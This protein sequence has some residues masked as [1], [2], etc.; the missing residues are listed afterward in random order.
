MLIKTKMDEKPN[1]TIIVENKKITLAYEE[2]VSKEDIWGICLEIF[3]RFYGERCRI[4]I[5]SVMPHYILEVLKLLHI[6]AKLNE[7]TMDVEFW[8][9]KDKAILC[10]DDAIT[11]DEYRIPVINHGMRWCAMNISKMFKDEYPE[12]YDFTDIS[13]S[14]PYLD[15]IVSDIYISN[16]KGDVR[17]ERYMAESLWDEGT[18]TYVYFIESKEKR[19]EFLKFLE[20]IL[21]QKHIKAEIK[22]EQRNA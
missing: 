12:E 16:E 15:H 13:M 8:T 18:K 22:N 21:K 10:L 7:D 6:D 5:G 4:G 19:D 20:E 2:T 9:D 17:F 1:V 14:M 11:L 3:D